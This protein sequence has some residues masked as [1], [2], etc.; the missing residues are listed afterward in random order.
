M[1]QLDDYGWKEGNPAETLEPGKLPFAGGNW[2]SEPYDRNAI[3][4]L[5]S[6]SGA[7]RTLKLPHLILAMEV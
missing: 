1:Q 3:H 5:L 7:G 6:L 4:P 2:P